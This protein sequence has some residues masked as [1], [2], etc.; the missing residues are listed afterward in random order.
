MRKEPEQPWAKLLKPLERHLA[1][2]CCTLRE[3]AVKSALVEMGEFGEESGRARISGAL[4]RH[5]LVELERG[6]KGSATTL[7]FRELIVA[8]PLE[9]NDLVFERSLLFEDCQFRGPVEARMLACR[10]LALER[11]RLESSFD[12]RVMSLRG[13]LFVR[14]T[15]A[16][17]PVIIRDC[18]AD[19]VIDCTGSSFNFS[20]SGNS[21]PGM[22]A[23]EHY[24]EAFGASR[25]RARALFWREIS[26]GGDGDLT[27]YDAEVGS[28]RDDLGE[29]GLAS[30]PPRGALKM[31]G[32]NYARKNAAPYHTHLA[33]LQRDSESFESNG[34]ILVTCLEAA[35]ALDDATK[36]RIEIRRH[37][38][39]FERSTVRRWSRALYLRLQQLAFSPGR[40][41]ILLTML[42]LL[43]G[44]LATLL[45][46]ADLIV[47]V[48]GGIIADGCFARW[49]EQCA[50]NGWVLI[51]GH[52]YALPGALRH[53]SGF[54]Y[55]L[56]LIFPYRPGAYTVLWG[57]AN[58]VV[59]L[60]L[61]GLRVIGLALQASLIWS[62]LGNRDTS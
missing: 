45:Y 56:D 49:T 4:L 59:S 14:H 17:G 6:L 7:G 47:P 34:R 43:S 8:G 37:A 15:V 55:A 13:N 52:N 60:L 28:F 40:V 46:N 29:R 48:D 26:F 61:L 36:L 35:S 1:Q 31:R 22:S 51:E 30:W 58:T 41:L 53:F 24:G 57:G 21:D 33:W 5:L 11:C 54:S 38:N 9:L 18:S 39:R 3:P 25:I 16:A 62:L 50:A 27:F 20:P 10:T 2:G 32:F 12:G 19:G 42:Y 23:K 44:G